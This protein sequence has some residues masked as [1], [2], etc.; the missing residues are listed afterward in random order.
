MAINITTRHKI[1]CHIRHKLLYY[2]IIYSIYSTNDL[3]LK[4]EALYIILLIIISYI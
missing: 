1:G 2:I 4:L 3:T